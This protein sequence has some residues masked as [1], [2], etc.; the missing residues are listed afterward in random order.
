MFQAALT[1]LRPGA[2]CYVAHA[3]TERVTFEAA[4]REAGYLLRQNLIWVKNALVLGR[5]DYQYKH[6]PILEAVVPGEP[7]ETGDLSDEVTTHEPVLYG[8]TPGGEGRLGRGS[9]NWYGNNKK[10]TVFEVPKPTASRDHPTMKPVELIVLQLRNSV[11]R[12]GSVLDMFAGSGSTLLAAH[13]LNLI[14][15]LV[16]L[17]PVYCD[18]ICRRW[19]EHTDVMPILERTG[20]AV[21]FIVEAD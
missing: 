15:R 1:V 2:P 17:D 20:E 10:T 16:E 8:F 12:G 4:L 11:G 5:S 7:G 3:D 9:T 6:E 19:Q 18:V 13:Q 21:S 14:A